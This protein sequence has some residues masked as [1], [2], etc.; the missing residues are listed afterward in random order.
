M[1]KD[2]FKLKIKILLKRYNDYKMLAK[3]ER[4][5]AE[6]LRKHDPVLADL[7]NKHIESAGDVYK[8]IFSR[9]EN[10]SVG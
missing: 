1:T 2:M 9:V 7:L 8:Y 4:D 10:N 5:T 6:E 3:F